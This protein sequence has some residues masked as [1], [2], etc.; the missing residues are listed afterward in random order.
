MKFQK[1]DKYRDIAVYAGV[2]AVIVALVILLIINFPAVFGVLGRIFKVFQPV[3]YGFIMA[4]LINPIMAFY[5]N[6]VFKFKKAKKNRFVLRR[7]LSLILAII[8]VLVILGLLVYAIVPA[9]FNS[10]RDFSGNIDGYITNLKTFADD[11]VAK[12]SNLFFRQDF[13]SARELLE[14]YDVHFSLRD[15]LKG[16]MNYFGSAF[17]GAVN[18]ATAV[19]GQLVNILIGVFLMV[20][21]LYSKEKLA[22]MAKKIIAS[23]TSRRGYVNVVRVVRYTNRS[24][25]G[26]ISGKLIDSAIMGLFAFAAFGIFKIPYSPLLAVIVGVTNFVPTFGPIFGGIIGGILLILAAPSKVI[27][28]LLIVLVIQQL[29]GNIIGPA[30]LGESIGISA[31]WVLLALTI[32]GGLFG[33]TGLVIGVPL[34]A[35]IYTLIKQFTEDRLKKKN[36]PFHTAFYEKDPSTDGEAADHIAF[37][38]KDGDVPEVTAE[39]DI[40][41]ENKKEKVLL[42]QR[43]RNLFKKKKDKKS[44]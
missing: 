44:K 43:I 15:M 12:N 26:F 28:F 14:A 25:G 8:T 19:V 35:V 33:F 36:M 2:T 38:P 30:I 41:P 7:V 5:E 13:N 42:A 11:A 20:Y 6:K 4:Y 40:V 3:L 39:D 18:I 17:D 22:A 32:F 34:M 1:N 24:F 23:F 21:F 16:A 31:L 27:P 37:I 29:D 9:A 10:F